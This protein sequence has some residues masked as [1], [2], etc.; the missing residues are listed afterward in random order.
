[1]KASFTSYSLPETGVLFLLAPDGGEPEQG[2]QLLG[3]DARD[4][5]GRAMNSAKFSGKRDEMVA[6]LSPAGSKLDRIVILGIGKPD[7]FDALAAENAGAAIAVYAKGAKLN[8]VGVLVE[9]IEGAKIDAAKIAAHMALGA[10]L[11]SYSFNKYRTKQTDEQK[12][13]LE[14]LSIGVGEPKNAEQ[15][16]AGL[17]SIITGVTLTRDLVTEPPNILYPESFAARAKDELTPLGVEV[18]ILDVPAM[19]KLGMGAL[20]AVGQG[21]RKPPRLV[22]MRW[23]GAASKDDQPIAFIGKGITFDTGGISLK[24]GAGMDEMKFDMGGAGAVI[25]LMATLA[26]RKAKANVIGVAAM[27]EN[28]PDGNAYRPG[29]VVTS[30]SGQTIEVLNTDAEGRMVLCDALWYTQDRFKPKFMVD[31][32]TLTGAVIVALGD[33][34]AGIMSNDDDL[35]T[36]LVTAGHEAGELLW[37][38][39]LTDAFDK[40]I[41]SD[42]ADVKHIAADRNAGTC[43]GGQFLKRFVNDVP[44]AHLDI[45]GVAW[46]K[47]D[48]GTTPK[49]ASGYGVRLLDAFVR[50]NFEG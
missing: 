46:F 19:E 43:I 14:A 16:F 33:Q 39:P 41:D 12:L 18:E 48:K 20:L 31:L 2:L 37:R 9:G 8:A 22:V 10:A 1:M 47:K 44:W 24:P 25:G 4:A 6:I 29:D 45:A 50:A 17:Q 36:K 28:M 42:I 13:S 26:G 40:A 34:F 32:A 5:V 30:M 7:A 35:A 21:S 11:R 27:A 23:N 49:G 3:E 38:L 15:T